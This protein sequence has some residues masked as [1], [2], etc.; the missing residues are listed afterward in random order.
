MIP[1][2]LE[3][4]AADT[5]PYVAGFCHSS[6]S[7]RHYSAAATVFLTGRRS[8]RSLRNWPVRARCSL[9]DR[10][11]RTDCDDFAAAVATF[12]TEVEDPVS[13]LDDFKVVLDN[14]H[15]VAL[16]DKFLQHFQQF[17]YVM[18]MQTSGRL[19]QDIERAAGRTPRQ[20][21]GKLDALR[22]TAGERVRLLADLDVA[23]A[24][25][26]QG[27]AACRE[28]PERQRRNRRLPR[29]SCRARRRST[30]A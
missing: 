27:P 24:D 6:S 12:G 15:R 4:P 3:G 11:G 9:D 13:R 19:V 5:D 10:L 21:L 29:P 16:I 17:G 14:H 26:F 7:S 18:E 8:S 28:L 30:S 20:L 1:P 23:E 2:R 22:L 25:V